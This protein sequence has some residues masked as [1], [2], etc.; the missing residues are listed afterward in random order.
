MLN[1]PQNALVPVR[2]TLPARWPNGS[3]G[4]TSDRSAGASPDLAALDLVDVETSLGD[5]AQV[6]KFLPDILG[7]ALARCWID[8]VFRA[9][10]LAD[11]VRT[12]SVHRIRLPASIR[13]HVV[14]EGQTRPMVVVSEE[15]LHG[16]PARRLLYLQL[17]MVAGK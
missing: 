11:P 6:E 16:S 13:I 10:F 2:N 12:L 4:Y 8:R 3:A 14:T 1:G 17:V 5:R 9:A 15:G 7:R